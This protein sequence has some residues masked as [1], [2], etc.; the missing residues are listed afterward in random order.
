MGGEAE[1]VVGLVDEVPVEGRGDVEAPAG[2]QHARQLGDDGP[3]ARR[4]LEH[5]GAERAVEAGAGERQRRHVGARLHVRAGGA[6]DAD[7]VDVLR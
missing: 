7:I 4:L 6:I 2:A 3:R 5:L 1:V